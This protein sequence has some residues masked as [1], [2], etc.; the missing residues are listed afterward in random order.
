MSKINATKV[1]KDSDGNIIRQGHLGTDVYKPLTKIVE[2]GPPAKEDA[3]VVNTED[4]TLNNSSS[5]GIPNEELKEDGNKKPSDTSD[6]GL[7][8]EMGQTESG[9][10]EDLTNSSDAF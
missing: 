5:E 7:N 2:S 6:Q 4:G 8:G 9:S 10:T 1:V 3:P